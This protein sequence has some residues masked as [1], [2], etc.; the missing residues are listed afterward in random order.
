MPK[1][2]KIQTNFTAGEM[3]QSVWGRID[4]ERYDSGLQ[5]CLNYYPIVQGP[6]IRRAGTKYVGNVKD[7]TQP[8]V[9]YPFQVSGNQGYQLEFGNYYCRFFSNDG[10]VLTNTTV[11]NI[12]GIYTNTPGFTAFI[13][14][15]GLRSTAVPSPGEVIQNSS[16]LVIGNPLELPTPFAYSEVHNLRFAQNGNVA[17]I[18]HPNHPPYKLIRNSDQ[19]WDLKQISTKD[20]PY[21]QLNTYATLADGAKINFAPSATG[22]PTISTGSSWNIIAASAFG[23]GEIL[24]TLSGQHQFSTGDQVY[25]TGVPGTIEA[26][27]NTSSIAASYWTLSG[28]P[29]VT[30]IRLANSVFLNTMTGSTGNCYPALFKLKANGSSFV[31]QDMLPDCSSGGRVVG[32]SSNGTRFWGTINTVFNPAQAQVIMD[33]GS[34]LPN[35][36]SISIWQ[37]GVYNQANGYPTTTCLHQNRLYLAGSPGSPQQFD[38]SQLG[39]YEAFAASGSNLQVVD[40]NA[41]SF[42]LLS[43]DV[44]PIYWMKPTSQG[45]LAGTLSGEWQI[46]PSNQNTGITPTNITVQQLAGYG[47]ANIESILV[48]NQ[49]IYLQKAQRKVRELNYFFQAGT[50]RSTNI[51][52]LSE[53]LTLPSITKLVNQKETNPAIWALRSD[54][55]LLSLTYNRDDF[56]LKAGWARHTLGGQSDAVRLRRRWL[57]AYLL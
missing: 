30:Q 11:F 18:I 7:S 32:L 25:I 27:N 34:I 31:W 29:S 45:L 53:H 39:S 13:R 17:Y 4:N 28:I 55:Q 52:E 38:G 57:I 3:S 43:Q 54:G 46:S 20:G 24:L 10:Q 2:T 35:T 56:S 9:L 44:Q 36:S 16:V 50:F 22:V 51:S 5:I 33:P 49:V 23:T 1:F 6:L 14:Y 21:L 19:N 42:N 37:L 47:S 48:G 8:G 40:A 26:N 15:G 12:G 41:V